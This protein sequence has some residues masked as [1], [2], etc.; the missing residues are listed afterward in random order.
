[1]RIFAQGLR[2]IYRNRELIYYMILREL[3]ILKRGAVFGVFW[4]IA[5][6]V[7]QVFLYAVVIGLVFKVKFAATADS[8][9]F[10]YA[11]FLLSGMIFWTAFTRACSEGSGLIR[12]H[13]PYIKQISYPVETIAIVRLF[14][15]AK[16]L[17]LGLCITLVLLFFSHFAY[18]WHL[19]L[20]PLL[21]AIFLLFLLGCMWL[22][23]VIGVVFREAGQVV[24][25]ALTWLIYATPIFYPPSFEIPGGLRAAIGMNPLSHVIFCFRYAVIGGVFPEKSFMLMLGMA[26]GFAY[27]GLVLIGFAK[28]KIGDYL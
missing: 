5:H 2:T 28:K 14:L 9:I 20:L 3:T 25:L 17:F 16:D 10:D 23:S 7:I 21:L 15:V 4:N 11:V 22:I 18:G 26:A 12:E 13:V 1:M 19:V 8:G 27:F 24:A 6:P